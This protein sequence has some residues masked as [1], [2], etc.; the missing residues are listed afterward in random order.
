ML[1]KRSVRLRHNADVAAGWVADRLRGEE[2]TL[3]SVLETGPSDDDYEETSSYLL[4]RLLLRPGLA[5]V[6]ALTDVALVAERSLL[7]PGVLAGGNLLPAGGGAHDLWSAFG[8]AWHPVVTGTGTDAPP[9]LALLALLATVL[10]GKAWLAVDLLLLGCVPLAGWTAYVAAGRITRTVPLRVWAA[11]TYALLPVATGALATGRVGVAVAFVLLPL[12]VLAAVRLVRVDP[13]YDGWRHVGTAALLLAAV[14]AFAPLLYLIALPALLIA[15]VGVRLAAPPPTQA[16]AIRRTLAVVVVAGAPLVLLWP[17]TAT[18]LSHPRVVLTTPGPAIAG[19][20]AHRLASWHL[21]VGAP[22]G[23]G[24]PPVWITVPL[25]LAGLAG[26]VRGSAQ[27]IA[28]CAWTLALLALAVGVVVAHVRVGAGFTGPARAVVG[29]PG[30]PAAVIG[31]A[32]VAAA[33]VAGNGARARLARMSF[34]WRQPVAAIVAAG[35]A[36]V[37]AL[38]AGVWLATGV[39]GPLH[40]TTRTVLPAFAAAEAATG[41]RP[42]ILALRVTQSGALSFV[43]LRGRP[44]QL[45]DGDVTLRGRDVRQLDAAVADLGAARGDDPAAALATYGIGYVLMPAPVAPQLA[46]ILDRT[47][48]LVR[49]TTG[50]SG[51]I[52]QVTTPTGRLVVLP[53]VTGARAL[54][55]TTPPTDAAALTPSPVPLPAGPESARSVLPGGEPGRLLVLAESRDDGWRASLDGHDLEPATAWGWAQA[56]RLPAGGGALRV[57]HSPGHRTGQLI[58][59]GVLVL[60]TLLLATP[61]GRRESG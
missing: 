57:W 20:T 37:P 46:S 10:L 13:G 8:S 51:V 53:A 4:R 34:S 52:W 49:R 31:A 61:T 40:R 1:A 11:A 6:A 3:R 15:T 33:V 14:T 2:E 48:G 41:A 19:T 12:L 32:I 47:Q 24:G 27:L 22:G 54:A 38:A 42:Q 60:L 9:Y 23:P 16:A 59:E 45:G 50:G 55:A 7:G 29:W 28:R 5:L 43:L 30:V 18:A 39:D 26:L 25:L 17:W 21:A 35:A 44:L 58:L 36:A 56:F